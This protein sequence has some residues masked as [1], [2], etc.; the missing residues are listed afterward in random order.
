MTE[1]CYLFWVENVFLE[2]PIT[3]SLQ[4]AS[5]AFTSSGEI[6]YSSPPSSIE[7]AVN[8]KTLERRSRFDSRVS[9]DSNKSDDDVRNFTTSTSRDTLSSY[10]SVDTE[11]YERLLKQ[12]DEAME[13]VKVRNIKYYTKNKYI[14]YFFR[15]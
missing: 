6:S 9:S 3:N 2:S 8:R 14:S 1:F 5:L 10:A 7:C 4:R 12:H 11:T 13:L 15:V